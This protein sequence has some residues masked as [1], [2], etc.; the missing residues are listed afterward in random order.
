MVDSSSKLASAAW[1]LVLGKVIV[2]YAT[3]IKQSCIAKTHRKF[4][5]ENNS[6]HNQHVALLQC[7]WCL[8]HAQQRVGGLCRHT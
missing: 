3:A 4:T 2:S 1:S 5:V 6:V 8:V 7:I